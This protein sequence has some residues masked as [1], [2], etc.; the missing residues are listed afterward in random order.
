MSRLTTWRYL[1][2]GNPAVSRCLSAGANEQTIPAP[3]PT[4]VNTLATTPGK[5]TLNTCRHKPT[6]AH[7]SVSTATRLQD[8]FHSPEV[9]RPHE[10]PSKHSNPTNTADLFLRAYI[11]LECKFRNLIEKQAPET[12]IPL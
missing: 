2:P 7:S 11:I 5:Y 12:E 8:L 4:T 9:P 3:Y 10:G 1:G 6:F